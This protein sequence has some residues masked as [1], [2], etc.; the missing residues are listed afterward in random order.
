MIFCLRYI[1][2]YIKMECTKCHKKLSLSNFSYKNA[3][4]KIYYLHCNDCRKKII[5]LQKNNKETIKENYNNIKDSNKIEC[6]C[7][8]CYVAFRKYHITR[9]E[10][11]K[12]HLLFEG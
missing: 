6:K 2:Y 8:T 12:K 11:S 4:E 3:K 5:N 7:G 1:Y 10:N 9:H